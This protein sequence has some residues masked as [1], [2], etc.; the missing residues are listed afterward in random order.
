MCKQR[1]TDRLFVTQKLYLAEIILVKIQGF[2]C[3]NKSDERILME[4][5]DK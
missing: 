3:A 4:R 5:L 1:E 2:C